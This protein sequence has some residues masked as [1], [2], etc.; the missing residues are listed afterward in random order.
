M[1]QWQF[2]LVVSF[3]SL[4]GCFVPWCERFVFFSILFLFYLVM[5]DEDNPCSV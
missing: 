1:L 4:S 2:F 3:F 5:D